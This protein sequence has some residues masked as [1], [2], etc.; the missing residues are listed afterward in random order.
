MNWRLESVLILDPGV[1]ELPQLVELL[2]SG[3]FLL[4]VRRVEIVKGSE[5]E[6]P[7]LGQLLIE[8]VSNLL[9][10][11]LVQL[12]D[13]TIFLLNLRDV[14]LVLDD[15]N[16]SLE[17]VILLGSPHHLLLDDNLWDFG[18]EFS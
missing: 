5:V 9:R 8:E 16:S 14:L 11:E 17:E 2:K 6:D 10:V 3:Q 18:L 12:N 1:L 7:I 13:A 4:E 15:L